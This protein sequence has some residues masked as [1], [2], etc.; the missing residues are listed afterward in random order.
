MLRFIS[1][2]A[3]IIAISLSFF[4][5]GFVLGADVFQLTFKQIITGLVAGA[6]C[7]VTILAIE[8]SR[9]RKQLSA[10]RERLSV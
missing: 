1:E 7:G 2:N 5:I 3:A 9:S 8:Y 6:V 10:V 4:T